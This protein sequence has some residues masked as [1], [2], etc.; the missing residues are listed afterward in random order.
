MAA[1]AHN[2][3]DLIKSFPVK[4]NL[5]VEILGAFRPSQ[6]FV[7]QTDPQFNS[8]KLSPLTQCFK[9]IQTGPKNR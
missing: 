9:T 3:N 4:R 8:F 7:I 1:S 6:I 2:F 5:I